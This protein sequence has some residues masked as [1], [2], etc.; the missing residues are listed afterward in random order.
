MKRIILITAAV[1]MALILSACSREGFKESLERGKEN[2]GAS[3]SEQQTE[4]ELSDEDFIFILDSDEYEED[5]CLYYYALP[6]ADSHAAENAANMISEELEQLIKSLAAQVAD[7]REYQNIS[8]YD[9]ITQNNGKIFSVMYEIE[10]TLNDETE[11]KYEVGLV[12]DPT[13]GE[14]IELDELKD[15]STFVTLILDEQLSKIPGKKED[16]KAKKRD[17]LREQGDEKLEKRLEAVES[18]EELLDASYY[19][20]GDELVAV[21]AADQEIGGVIEVSVAM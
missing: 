11:E 5:K 8:I 10:M 6:K 17:Y 3:S 14:R 12:F 15:S 4:P 21:F 7:G 19:V 16:V 13:T 1:I 18:I 2:N 9:A 20:D